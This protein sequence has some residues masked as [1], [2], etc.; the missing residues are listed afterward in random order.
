MPSLI[1]FE[2]HPLLRNGHLQTIVGRYLP[3]PKHVPKTK[4]HLV[5]LPDG[6]RIALCENKPNRKSTFSK[7]IVLMH[8]LAGDS[9]SSYMVRLA[10]LLHGRGW[11]VFRMNHRGSGE[12]RRLAR[13]LYHAGKSDDVS[14]VLH[15]V[16]R[17]SN[18]APTIA[19]GFS[20]SGNMV[21]HLL[22]KK[23]APIPESL[24]GAIAVTP[25]IELALCSDSLARAGNRIY[26][27]RFVRKLRKGILERE[28]TYPDFP[29]FRTV[30]RSLREFDEICTAPMCGFESADDYYRKCSAKQCLD[31]IT[32]PTCILAAADDPFIP[33]CTFD[34]MPDNPW[35]DLIIAT[36]GG[37]MG[38]VSAERTPLG[39]RKWLDYAVVNIAESMLHN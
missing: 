7:A 12:G 30:G 5:A 4:V 13:H 3:A 28:S 17:L 37:H 15:E 14:A 23:D 38:F 24:N 9:T 32:H 26:D 27:F 36:G 39:D 8:G 10:T 2:P 21:L 18:N 29:R 35:V 1:S 34:N 19:V 22:G 31:A 16:A 6:D 20:L 25:P 33:T 11:H